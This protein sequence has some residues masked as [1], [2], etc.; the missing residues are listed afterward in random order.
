MV[1][2]YF[3]FITVISLCL[4]TN[5]LSPNLLFLL[6]DDLGYADIGW[7]NATVLSPNLDALALSGIRLENYYVQPICSP[8]RSSL[9]TGRYTYRLGTQATVIR[10]DVPFGIPLKE[11]FMSQNL[12]DAGYHTAL[13][14]KWH[15]GFYQKDYTPLYRGFDEHMG[16]FA[17]QEDYYTHIGPGYGGTKAGL[18]W[19]RGNQSDCWDDTGNYSAP[20]IAA[21]AISFLRQMHHQQTKTTNPKPFFLYLPWHLVH[22]PNQVPDEYKNRYPHLTGNTQIWLGKVSALDDAIGSVIDALKEFGL[23]NNTII[24]FSADNG[25]PNSGGSNFPLKG[26][27][28]QLYEGGIKADA[29]VHSPLLPPSLHGTVNKKLF[30]VVDWLPTLVA[31]AGGKTIHNQPLDGKDIWSALTDIDSPSPHQELLINLNP[32]CGK[33]YVNPDAGIRA[34]QYKLLVNCFNTTT[35]LPQGTVQLYDLSKDPY[36]TLNLAKTMPDKVAQLMKR[37][38]FYSNSTDQYSPTI[39]SPPYRQCPQCPQGGAQ[40]AHMNISCKPR[41]NFN[42]IAGEVPKPGQSV[43]DNK[44]GVII[45]F[46][47]KY[48]SFKECED[49]C[50]HN[51]TPIDPCHSWT[52]HHPDAK[53]NWHNMCYG[54]HDQHWNPKP[55][56]GNPVTCGSS[57]LYP[58]SG[59]SYNPWCD[60]IHCTPVAN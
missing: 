14:G 43:F 12:K 35:H 48:E 47:G 7:H 32:A 11:T 4:A 38:T 18:D 30:H 8:T 40:L 45:Y 57:C 59:L 9:M 13:F 42:N 23:Y 31:L 28:T 21:K 1:R 24:F 49:A 52:F 15:L 46:L 10:A 58:P 44:T 6:A 56:H 20:L 34:G 33:G 50:K 2:N 53:G 22:G 54:R 27:K 16:Y 29:F 60:N 36:E 3:L 19:H 37:L 51:S 5:P 55:T 39:F 25:A 41:E 17:G 26:W